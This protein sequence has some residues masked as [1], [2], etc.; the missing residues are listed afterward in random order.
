[1]NRNARVFISGPYTN[2]NVAVNVA[3]AVEAFHQLRDIGFNPFVPHL[4]HYAEIAQS[5][6]Y[7]DWM[8]LDLH[9]LSICDCVLRLPGE[10]S[11]ADREVAEAKRLGIPVFYSIGALVDALLDYESLEAP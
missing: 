3:A 6:P 8:Q 4:F 9:W 10:S 7:E 1:M 2:G 11:G 5:R